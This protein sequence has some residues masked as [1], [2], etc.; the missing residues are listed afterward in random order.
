[1]IQSQNDTIKSDFFQLASLT[2]AI[3]TVLT[4]GLHLWPFENSRML[5]TLAPVNLGIM[6][7]VPLAA[8]TVVVSRPRR[9]LLWE[10]LPDVSIW[11]FLAIAAMSLA[12]SPHFSQSAV[13][14]IKLM[15]MYVGGFV[16]FSLVCSWEGWA[17]RLCTM[18]LVSVWITMAVSVAWRILGYEG[19]GFFANPHKYGTVTAILFTLGCIHLASRTSVIAWLVVPLTALA[20]V[21][22]VSLAG[23]CGIIAGLLAGILV[24]RH[25]L[26]RLRLSI[27]LLTAIAILAILWQSQFFS[28]LRGDVQIMESNGRDLR[29]RYIE[30]Q[31]QLNLLQ[32]RPVT[33]TGLGCVNEYRSM[34]YGR[35]PKLNTLQP[36]DHNGWLLIA[37]ETGIFGLV[38]FVWMIVRAFKKAWKSSRTIGPQTFIAS[39][40]FA[41]LVTA[42][43]A[44]TFS[45]LNYNGVVGA[46]VLVL[47]L[48][49]HA[50]P[51]RP[52]NHSIVPDNIET[53]ISC[54][55]T[56]QLAEKQEGN[57]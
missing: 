38:T 15:L 28:P 54:R 3:W 56:P 14:L 23:I 33:G 47:A 7:W 51:I 40:A 55:S 21:A 29:Q 24:I 17:D 20:T 25:P 35:L 26:S 44:N 4:L 52:S 53:V 32:D 5:E 48:A 39:A 12:F 41:A 6:L 9:R 10:H 45:F 49:H 30:W 2:A 16:L 18:A 50:G 8:I 57:G 34:F 31:A 27:C 36:F 42:C 22:S 43:V 13:S 37:A 46:F 19:L 1:M 11:A